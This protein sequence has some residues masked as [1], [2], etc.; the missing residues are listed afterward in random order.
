MSDTLEAAKPLKFFAWDSHAGESSG[1]TMNA[2]HSHEA[3]ELFVINR[4]EDAFKEDSV[5]H[6]NVRD[7]SGN[8]AEFKVEIEINVTA[9]RR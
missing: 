1:K 2:F 7:E 4:L 9:R 3:A 8:V 5:H 6:I